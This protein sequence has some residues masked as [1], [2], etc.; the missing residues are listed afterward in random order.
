MA[1]EA[2]LDMFSDL[3]NLKQLNKMQT[4][5]F[6]KNG[7]LPEK[8]QMVDIQPDLM[9]KTVEEV[10]EPE[11]PKDEKAKE[12]E[13]PKFNVCQCCGWAMNQSYIP[14]LT[15]VMK[16]NF[17]DALV[18]LER[19]TQ[20]TSLFG[21]RVHLVFRAITQNESAACLELAGN[22]N[23]NPV[24]LMDANKYQLVCGIAAYGDKEYNELDS[25]SNPRPVSDIIKDIVDRSRQLVNGLMIPVYSAI[26]REFN[27]FQLLQQWIDSK[28]TDPDF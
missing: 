14:E 2:D 24:W 6:L 16:I 5:E 17:I 8:V 25:L 28:A 26:L 4:L 3:K 1:D 19:F 10:V 27:K 9:E 12:V 7:K 23:T 11:E 22:A 13:Q 20:S 21:G 15:D 18:K